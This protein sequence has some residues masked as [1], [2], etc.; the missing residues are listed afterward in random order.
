MKQTV[1]KLGPF[2][3]YIHCTYHT[4]K[5]ILKKGSDYIGCLCTDRLRVV[6]HKKKLKNCHF[7]SKNI[8]SVKKR[9]GFITKVQGRLAGREHIDR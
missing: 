2:H 1:V 4:Y 3:K 9:L 7:N 8:L 6:F 5:G